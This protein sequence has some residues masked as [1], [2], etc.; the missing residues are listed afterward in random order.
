MPGGDQEATSQVVRSSAGGSS[1]NPSKPSAPARSANRRASSSPLSAGT[2]IALDLLAVEAEPEAIEDGAEAELEARV[3]GV[4][5]SAGLV[6]AFPQVREPPG[7]FGL[8]V[9]GAG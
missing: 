3:G 1:W 5:V 9:H 7:D 8:L 4:E 6:E 2:V